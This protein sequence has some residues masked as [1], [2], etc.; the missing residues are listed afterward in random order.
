MRAR[1]RKLCREILAQEERDRAAEIEAAKE[2]HY[3][4][5]KSPLADCTPYAVP[6]KPSDK[7]VTAQ[8]RSA[9]QERVGQGCWHTRPRFIE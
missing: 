2:S 5:S 8:P 7:P 3:L 4:R 6:K 1:M 9:G